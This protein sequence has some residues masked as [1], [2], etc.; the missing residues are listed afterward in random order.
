MT[1]PMLS[2]NPCNSRG[3][4]DD[5]NSRAG[6]THVLDMRQAAAQAAAEGDAEAAEAMGMIDMWFG[7]KICEKEEER[8]NWKVAD[9]A[10]DDEATTSGAT[11]E[12]IRIDDRKHDV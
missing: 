9:W 2:S 1:S 4:N 10:E 12:W 5:T 3:P 8:D 7:L 6:G 11:Y